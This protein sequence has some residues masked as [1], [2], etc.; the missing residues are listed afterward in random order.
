MQSI[1]WVQMYRQFQYLLKEFYTAPYRQELAREKR[2]QDDL[3]MLLVFSEMMG[4]PNPVSFYT[5]ELLPLIYEDFHQWHQRMGMDQSP[6]EQIR[7]C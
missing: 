3:F 5:L 2:D 6:L 7:C 1:N 4:V